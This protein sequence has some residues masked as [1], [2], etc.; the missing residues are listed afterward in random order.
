MSEL[1]FTPDELRAQANQ[2]RHSAQYAQG[3]TRRDE[4]EEAQALERQ[5]NELERSNELQR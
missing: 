4:L 2:M 1:S 3:K 5:D